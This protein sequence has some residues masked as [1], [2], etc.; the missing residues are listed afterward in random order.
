MVWKWWEKA[1]KGRLGESWG[2]EGA[3]GTL[4]EKECVGAR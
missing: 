2:A 4:D 3:G 1:N